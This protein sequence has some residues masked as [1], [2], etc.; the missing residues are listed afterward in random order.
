LVGILPRFTLNG[1]WVGALPGPMHLGIR[2]GPLWPRYT[3]MYLLI[4]T[5]QSPQW[6]VVSME[7]EE[8]SDN[9]KLFVISYVTC[10]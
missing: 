7:E 1:I 9:I 8:I 5:G 2:T 4:S 10:E 3:L 6:A